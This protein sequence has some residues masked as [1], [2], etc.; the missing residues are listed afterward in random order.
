MSVTMVELQT[1]KIFRS[2]IMSE[3]SKI[4]IHL[5]DQTLD[6]LNSVKEIL[7]SH[8]AKNNKLSKGGI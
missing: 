3:I 4:V 5:S 1:D 8:L 2:F 7:W 6:S